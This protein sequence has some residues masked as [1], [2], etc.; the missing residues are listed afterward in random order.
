[1]F[2]LLMTQ[3]APQWYCRTK[4]D[5]DEIGTG[6]QLR[7]QLRN[8]LFAPAF[9]FNLLMLVTAEEPQIRNKHKPLRCIFQGRIDIGYR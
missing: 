4:A 6:L 2:H 3:G 5:P 1:L 8:W 9:P 7:G